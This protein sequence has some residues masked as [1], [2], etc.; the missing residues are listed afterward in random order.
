MTLGLLCSG[1]EALASLAPVGG[2]LWADLK[3]LWVGTEVPQAR[4]LM[5]G[6][7]MTP[8][9]WCTSRVL[10][11]ALICAMGQFS[12]PFLGWSVC[13]CVEGWGGSAFQ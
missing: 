10:T 3:G 8:G 4:A 2:A 11:F 7:G 5:P 6:P 9:T 12:S 1:D 13:V